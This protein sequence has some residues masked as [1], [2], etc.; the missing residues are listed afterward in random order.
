ML[1]FQFRIQIPICGNVGA[2]GFSKSFYSL[3]DLFQGR[4]G[5]IWKRLAKRIELWRGCHRESM[6]LFAG[7]FKGFLAFVGDEKLRELG[8]QRGDLGNIANL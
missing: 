8:L 3:L 1:G 4:L 5:T 2:H 6:A 7:T